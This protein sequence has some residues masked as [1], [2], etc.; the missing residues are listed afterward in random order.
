LYVR[1]KKQDKERIVEAAG[2][3]GIAAWAR[4]VLLSAVARKRV[5]AAVGLAEGFREDTTP[6]RPAGALRR[7]CTAEP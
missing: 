2:D 4:G 3:S 1:L 7:R 6:R 5:K